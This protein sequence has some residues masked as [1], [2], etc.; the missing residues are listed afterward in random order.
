MSYRSNDKFHSINRVWIL[1][2]MADKKVLQ[3]WVTKALQE[4]GG[5]GS[6][7]EIV[8][9]LWR[10]HQEELKEAGD[11]FYTWQYDMRW[12]G[13]QLRKQNIIL[14][15]KKSPKGVWELSD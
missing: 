10:D 5:S 7:V 15:A 4:L 11:L 2:I 12:A 3:N 13:T 14:P 8:K 6:I 9:I 1:K